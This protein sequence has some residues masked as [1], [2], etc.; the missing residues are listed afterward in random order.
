VGKD[1]HGISTRKGADNY[2]L[3]ALSTIVRKNG[4]ASLQWIEAQFP[5]RTS[6]NMYLA[7]LSLEDCSLGNATVLVGEALHF[8]QHVAGASKPRS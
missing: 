5:S 2:Q 8:Q 1:Q 7:G 6:R 3:S 4:V